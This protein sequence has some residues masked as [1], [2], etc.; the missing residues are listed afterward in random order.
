MAAA[1][2]KSRSTIQVAM[3]GQLGGD[4]EGEMYLEY[5]KENDVDTTNINILNDQVT[6]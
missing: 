4:K 6:G 1:R 3:L 5:L 2:T